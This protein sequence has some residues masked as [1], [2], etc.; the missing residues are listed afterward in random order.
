MRRV[1]KQLLP[2]QST[3]WRLVTERDFVDCYSVASPLLPYEAMKVGL[4]MPV[5]VKALMGLRN[6][7]VAPFGL[8]T[9]KHLENSA[10][11]PGGD[12]GAL[13]P[14]TYRDESEVIVGIDDHHLD[15]RIAVHRAD[16]RIFMATWVRTHNL[17]GRT[18]LTVIMPFHV[19]IVRDC[20]KRIARA[21]S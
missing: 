8:K 1:R 17:L 5:W 20:M 18:Y 16:D 3:L 21:P 9:G 14:V 19:L 2:D 4:T 13:F 15:F 12:P 6:A 7:L 11:A 10:S